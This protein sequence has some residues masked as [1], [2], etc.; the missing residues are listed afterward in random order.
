MA[1]ST[2]A[3]EIFSNPSNLS[4]P[5]G[6]GEHVSKRRKNL[7]MISSHDD[8]RVWLETGLLP[9]VFG[10]PFGEAWLTF[11]NRVVGGVRLKQHR[12]KKRE[13][14]LPAQWSW[15][16]GGCLTDSDFSEESFGL[17]TE[18]FVVESQSTQGVLADQARPA[19][20][21]WFFVEH[22]FLV[23]LSKS[24]Y[25]RAFEWIG[26]ETADVIITL[27]LYNPQTE[28]FALS[29]ISFSFPLAGGVKASVTTDSV[30][31]S[32]YSAVYAKLH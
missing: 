13:C 9:S 24:S 15:P 22:S 26:R 20:D 30:F 5:L 29:E 1:L 4:S 16:E 27:P 18:G 31:V 23:S 14:T 25:L 10:N 32:T 21:F 19:F 7:E 12:Y 6:R 2:A 28:M 3:R 8:L 17:A 11:H